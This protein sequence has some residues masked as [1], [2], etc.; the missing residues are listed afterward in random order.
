MT[1]ADFLIARAFCV[2]RAGEIKQVNNNKHLNPANENLKQQIGSYVLFII[3]NAF[4][5]L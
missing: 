4:N 1:A 2:P 5:C 3:C